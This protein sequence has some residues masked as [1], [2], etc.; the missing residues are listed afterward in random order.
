MKSQSRVIS[1]AKANKGQLESLLSSLYSEFC[2]R[3]HKAFLHLFTDDV[4]TLIKIMKQNHSD[5][6][7]VFDGLKIEQSRRGCCSGENVQNE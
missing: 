3:Y 1:E 2:D 7:V 4:K 5:I 6:D